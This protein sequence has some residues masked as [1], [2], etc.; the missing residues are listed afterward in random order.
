LVAVLVPPNLVVWLSLTDRQPTQGIPW[1]ASPIVG[2][3]N[4]SDLFGD[5]RFGGAVLRTIV[6]VVVVVISVLAELGLRQV[7]KD[8]LRLGDSVLTGLPFNH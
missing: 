2:L 6:I 5:R 1:S 3:W 4:F 7:A 8:D